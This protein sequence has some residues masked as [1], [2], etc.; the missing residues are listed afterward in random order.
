MSG[1]VQEQTHGAPCEVGK[2]VSTGQRR[3]TAQTLVLLFRHPDADHPRS[4]LENF[5]GIFECW[6]G[7]PERAR[8]NLGMLRTL[9]SQEPGTEKSFLLFSAA[10]PP[11]AT[12]NG[13]LAG[14]SSPKDWVPRNLAQIQKERNE[15]M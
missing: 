14:E 12:I 8:Q 9:Q 4:R 7:H 2:A 10:M 15:K 1:D 5:H 11:L 3:K 13:A 6:S